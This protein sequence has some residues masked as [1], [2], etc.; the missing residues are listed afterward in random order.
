M[1]VH[2]QTIIQ[3]MEQFAPKNFAVEHDTIGLQLGTLDKK[4]D[5]VLVTLDVT[6]AVVEEAI[7]IGAQL[8]IAHHAI[9]FRP[10]AKID[11]STPAGK[12]YELLIKND[13]AVYISHTNL[14]VAIGG[15]NDLLADAAGMLPE[16]RKIL[17]TTYVDSMYKLVVFIPQKSLESVQQAIWR[18][19]GGHIGNYSHCSYQSAGVG[20][21]M[22][23]ENS[24]P[25]VGKKHE[26]HYEEEVRFECIVQSSNQR[27]VIQ[28]MIKAHPYEEVA[29]DLI[30]IH[31]QGTHYGLGRSGAL[32][33]PTTLGQLANK[34]KL[35]YNVPSLRVVGD[36]NKPI[37]KIAVLGGMGAK[38]VKSAKFTGADVLI[39]GD[40]DFHTAHDA[41]A[42][43]MTIIDPGHHIEQVM[44]KGVVNW[45]TNKCS[46]EKADVKIIASSV[47]T[48]P[49]TFL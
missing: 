30:P 25:H 8:I 33:E 49:F 48:E 2:G 19:G 39:T 35:A 37:K 16:G 36:L 7:S 18:A 45:L 15:V 43:G 46:K 24:N 12:L 31:N 23:D 22:A 27:K 40:I 44:I 5:T 34:V 11:T 6:L 32:A 1:A 26:L 3:Y 28:A 41:L 21:F 29:Y 42:D 10:I 4:I 17:E 9:I 20:T 47:H 38:Y 14:D 13:I